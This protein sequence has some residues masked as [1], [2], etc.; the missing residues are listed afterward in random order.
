M[1]SSIFVGT[2]GPLVRATLEQ[3]RRNGCRKLGGPFLFESSLIA[4][5]VQKLGKYGLSKVY[6]QRACLARA[7]GANLQPQGAARLLAL[8]SSA[9]T[10]D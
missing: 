1:I 5:K 6:E 2:S 4:A 9:R 3:A 10:Y 8:S 7:R